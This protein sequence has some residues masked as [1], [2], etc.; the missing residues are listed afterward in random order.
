MID[1]PEISLHI[2]WQQKLGEMIQKITQNKMGVQVIMTTHSPFITAGNTNLLVEAE[3][4]G[5]DNGKGE[6]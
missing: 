4:I 3:L 2:A 6:Q 5:D 1:E